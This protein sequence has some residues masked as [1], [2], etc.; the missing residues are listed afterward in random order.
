MP[1]ARRLQNGSFMALS[2]V[3]LT[4]ALPGVASTGLDLTQTVERIPLPPVA[5]PVTLHVE[6]LASR[7]RLETRDAAEVARRVRLASRTLCPEVGV[8]GDAVVLRC[9]SRFIA[10]AL[11]PHA[12]GQSLEVRLLQVAPWAGR[13]GLPSVPFD[14]SRLSLGAPCPGD[15]PAGAGECAL[16]AGQL[17][18]AEE[19]FRQAG[20]GPGAPLAALRLGDLAARADDLPEAV[21]HWKQVAPGSPFGR[22]AA[23]RLCETDPRCLVSNRAAFLFA[24]AD[25]HP[26]LRADLVLRQAR[27]DAFH[28]KALEAA[29][30]LA[31]DRG[32]AGAC[33]AEPILCGDIL[34]AALREPGARG[35]QALALY[36]DTPSRDRGPLAVEL[37]RAGSE[38][39]TAS[40][41]PVFAANLLSAV[42][43]QV[44][45]ARLADHLARAAELYLAG[46][47]RI[48]AG[49]V[50]E[51]ARSRLGRS[52]LAS[53]RWTRVALG[54][55]GR[56]SRTAPPRPELVGA[57]DDLGAAE[58]ALASA[59]ARASGGTP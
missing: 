56:P 38:R 21:R 59:R 15:A 29:M 54:V 17:Q 46:G 31:R 30:A 35:T 2:V 58:K 23:A 6:P 1:R 50:L 20:E 41:A 27:L 7:V 4:L 12:G 53:P 13:D 51:F 11:V 45:P 25:A 16:A 39:A 55:S 10:A 24:T 19:L 37:A 44:P 14:P 43:G 9:T 18:R 5:G 47:D 48:R 40:G 34:L 33:A 8:E 22:L 28:G 32:P 26:A 36:L 49:V 42:S 3:L 57:E 52:D